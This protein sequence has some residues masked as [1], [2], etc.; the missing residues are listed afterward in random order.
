MPINYSLI[1]KKWHYHI[2]VAYHAKVRFWVLIKGHIYVR[3]I[4]VMDLKLFWYPINSNGNSIAGMLE[5][6]T[7]IILFLFLLFSDHLIVVFH[8]LS[9]QDTYNIRTLHMLRNWT[10]MFTKFSL[11]YL[12]LLQINFL[13]SDYVHIILY[14][15]SL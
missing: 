6:N 1:D 7:V 4:F 10:E 13:F 3:N 12:F 2:K 14:I 9:M 5:N 15:F 11:F 8:F